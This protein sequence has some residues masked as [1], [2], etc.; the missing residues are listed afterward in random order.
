MKDALFA[1]TEDEAKWRKFIFYAKIKEHGGKAVG[2]HT[3]WP[4]F[5][6]SRWEAYERQLRGSDGYW[7]RCNSCHWSTE[8]GMNKWLYLTPSV[9]GKKR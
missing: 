3:S 2:T 1:I 5:Y 8:Q 9:F 7:C 6:L 4:A